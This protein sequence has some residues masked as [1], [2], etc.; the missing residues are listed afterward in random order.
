MRLAWDK[1]GAVGARIGGGGSGAVFEAE[2]SAGE[3]AAVIPPGARSAA[4]R[5]AIPLLS[6]IAEALVDLKDREIVHP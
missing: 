2:D 4:P 3:N 6:D 1:E 5:E